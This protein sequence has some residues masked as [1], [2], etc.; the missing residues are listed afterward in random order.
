MRVKKTDGASSVSAEVIR[1]F[2]SALV[3]RETYN[4]RRNTYILFGLLWGVPIPLLGVLLELHVSHVS[5]TPVTLDDLWHPLHIV[6]AL[7]PFF[8]AVLFGALGT[9]RLRKTARI[10]D[11]VEKLAHEI[12]RLARA[13]ADLQELD[14]L[15]DEFLGNVTHELKTPLVTIRGYAEMM[16][17]GRL[18][19]LSDKQARAIEVVR[20]NTLR[21]QEQIERLLA[22]SRNRERLDRLVRR[23]V[24]LPDLLREVEERHLPTADSRGVTLTIARPGADLVLWGDRERLLEVLDNL[25]SNAVKFTESGGRVDVRFGPPVGSRL[26][27]EVS[28]TGCGIPKEALEYIFDRF[29]QADGSIRR[30]YGGSGLG[31]A[32]VRSNLEAHGCGVRVE[33]EPGTGARFL[34]ELPLASPDAKD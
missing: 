1:E 3:A 26:P 17:S 21:L 28:D 27:A 8:F 2:L 7:H 12:K 20:R 32:I 4:P 6:L 16:E 10:E 34:F 13:N 31:L 5:G 14:R 9:I 25:V 19:P 15:K 30:T 24:P 23:K 22:C 33:S 29:R 18:G 11:L